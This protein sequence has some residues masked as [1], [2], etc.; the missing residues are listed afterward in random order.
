LNNKLDRMKA[1]DFSMMANYH[2]E[3]LAEIKE[4]QTVSGY[5]QSVHQCKEHLKTMRS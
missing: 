3:F 5:K 2:L 4:D 1:E